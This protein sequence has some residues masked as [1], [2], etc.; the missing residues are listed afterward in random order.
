MDVLRPATTGGTSTRTA[1]TVASVPGS[2]VYVRHISAEHD[3]GVRRLPDPPPATTADA[4]PGQWWPPA[5]LHPEWVRGHDF[6]VM[7]VQFGFDAWEPDYLESVVDA[8]HGEGRALV[9]TVHDLRNPHHRTRELHDAQ[10]EVLVRRADALLTLTDGAADEVLRRW[11]RRPAVLPHPHV[12]DLATMAQRETAPPLPRPDFRVG[13]HVKSLRASMDPLAL[14]PSLL[15]AVRQVPGGVLQ[16]NG[17]TDVLSPAGARHEPELARWLHDAARRGDVDLRV[18]DFLSD[19]DLWD[20]L[21]SLSVSVL[22]YRFGTHSGWLEA[23][24]DLGTAVV[25]PS[26]GYYAEQGPVHGFTLDEDDFDP[27]SLVR[28]VLEAHAAGPV[29]PL[30]VDVR[31]RQRAEV[32]A[33]HADVY[34]GLT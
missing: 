4:A 9:Y 6:D 34:R 23:C 26:C 2:H 24:R 27:A 18:H 5:M 13:L 31:R 32:A 25:A 29:A 17:H 33:A 3:D 16:V 19:T 8:V 12:V 22:P 15:E 20:Y 30:G 11:G 28:A 1:T 21:S 14:L 7:H 10:L